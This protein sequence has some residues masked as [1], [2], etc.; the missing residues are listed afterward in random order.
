MDSTKNLSGHYL[1]FVLSEKSRAELLK[2]FPP[3]FSKALCDHVTIEFN[4]KRS[5]IEEFVDNIDEVHVVQAIGYAGGDGVECVAVSIDGNTER[6]DGSFYHV[7]V[8]VEPP[9]KPVESNKL[10]SKV[11]RINAKMTLEGSF[12]FVKK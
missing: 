8:S 12:K 2:R 11:N 7:T 1:A 6:K 4:M 3:Q 9:H 5:T 10:E